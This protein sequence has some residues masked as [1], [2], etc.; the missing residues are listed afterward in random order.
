MRAATHGSRGH[1][2]WCLLVRTG[3]L[4]APEPHGLAAKPGEGSR[5]SS[6]KRLCHAMRQSFSMF[7]SA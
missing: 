3:L 7:C 4:S 2:S 1:R 6:S 5:G